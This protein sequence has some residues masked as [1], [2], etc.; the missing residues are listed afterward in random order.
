MKNGKMTGRLRTREGD[1]RKA[2]M[3][4]REREQERET[5][6]FKVSVRG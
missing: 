1:P 5:G 6:V 3:S 2:E 4:Q